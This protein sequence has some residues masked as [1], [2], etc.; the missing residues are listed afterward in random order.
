MI[1]RKRL[2]FLGE[3]I[4][5][6][7]PT[8]LD[9]RCGGGGGGGGDGGAAERE[10]ER[11]RRIAAGTDAVNRLFGVSGGPV[12]DEVL[13]TIQDNNSTVTDSGSTSGGDIRTTRDF[14]INDAKTQA[15]A[16]AAEEAR[17]AREA[18]YGTVRSDV[19]NFFSKQ[20]EED[21]SKAA[22]D[23]KFATARAGTGGS[24]QAIDLGREFQT[25]L[26]RGLLDVG[27]RADSAMTAVRSNDEQTRLG[28]ISKIV[29]GMDQ[30]SAQQ[31]A[32][33]Q[34]KTNADQSRDSAMS[35]RMSNVFSDLVGGYNQQ[36]FNAGAEQAKKDQ[37]GNVY[38][39]NTSYSGNVTR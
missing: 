25:R 13:T 20:L 9:R 7:L 19:G 10:A 34:L 18:M 37:F 23:M 21:K 35:S 36:Q 22:R 26:D 31:S 6:Q 2:E 38:P 30:G 14:V 28:L 5:P 33:N 8:R 3:P 12:Y 27:N 4:C 17:A 32:L 24:S 1:S 39:N 11:Q 15:A 16:Q 29:A